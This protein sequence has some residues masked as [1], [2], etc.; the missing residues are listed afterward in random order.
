MPVRCKGTESSCVHINVHQCGMPTSIRCHPKTTRQGKMY[1][2]KNYTMNEFA[3]LFFGLSGIRLDIK[4]AH[5][6]KLLATL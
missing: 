2:S 6:P 3:F 4:D 1:I 5:R